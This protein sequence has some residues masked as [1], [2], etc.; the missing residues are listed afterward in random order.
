MCSILILINMLNDTDPELQLCDYLLRLNPVDIVDPQECRDMV[1]Q[2]GEISEST[3]II[4]FNT[5]PTNII[6]CLLEA[7]PHPKE[8]L[9]SKAV[10]TK[11]TN[12]NALQ[13]LL[14]LHVPFADAD[15]VFAIAQQHIMHVSWLISSSP[16]P[17]D[18]VYLYAFE[19]VKFG[20]RLIRA[21]LLHKVPISEAFLYEC[22][23]QGALYFLIELLP[24]MK[25]E[26]CS[27]MF[28]FF[29]LEESKC[30]ISVQQQLLQY[31][32]DK[33]LIHQDVRDL[34]Y[35]IIQHEPIEISYG[36]L[37]GNELFAQFLLDRYDELNVDTWMGWMKWWKKRV[38]SS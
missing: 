8:R 23:K 5:C 25:A 30:Q 20:V 17:V 26:Q 34:A 3:L 37:S 33:T 15:I 22:L 27:K 1:Q 28:T 13:A 32:T 14:N 36:Y 10:S 24:S 12:T 16:S 6:T 11:H 9:Y 21:L 4:A 38:F 7:Y 2:L 18:W 19:D 35:R 29:L 31:I